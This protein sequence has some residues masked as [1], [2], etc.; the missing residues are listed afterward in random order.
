MS[1]SL[2]Y[3]LED[4]EE[5][6]RLYEREFTAHDYRVKIFRTIAE[7]LKALEAQSCDLCIL[8][9]SLPDGDGLLMLKN[10]ISNH[11][12][13]CI[14]VSG[15]GST[16]DKV[17]GL[18]FGADDYMVKPIDIIE[19]IARAKSIE[20]RLGKAAPEQDSDKY[21]FN[22]W[23]VDL[24][25]MKLIDPNNQ[26]HSLSLSDKQ[27]LQAFLESKGKILD[28]E[29]LLDVCQLENHDIFDRSIDVRVAR[30]RKKFNNKDVKN[31]FIKTVYGAGY[32]FV[33]KVS[34][35]SNT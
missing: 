18:E 22:D 24:S 32:L 6:C 17:L 33:P 2:V 3:I 26:A 23:Q 27:L 34:R 31:D 16:S 10:V 28:R 35:S 15:R 12:F 5:I 1:D 30:L 13:P 19:L 7:F 25:Q 4:N 21:Y 8:D 29:K 11:S 9:L 20:R 14:I